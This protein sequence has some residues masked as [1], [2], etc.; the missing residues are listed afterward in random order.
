MF[1]AEGGSERITHFNNHVFPTSR[2]N[3]QELY[4][5]NYQV[6]HLLS[7]FVVDN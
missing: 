6:G 3:P 1:D 2:I 5:S 4:P 7:T